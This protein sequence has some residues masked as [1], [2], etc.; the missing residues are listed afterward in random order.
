MKLPRTL[1]MLKHSILVRSRGE[2]VRCEQRVGVMGPFSTTT[3]VRNKMP[4]A[5]Q[6]CLKLNPYAG[7]ML[8]TRVSTVV[9]PI[10]LHTAGGSW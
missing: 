8:G 10:R 5:Q 1:A 4:T 3:R 6:H 7:L 9:Y 2:K